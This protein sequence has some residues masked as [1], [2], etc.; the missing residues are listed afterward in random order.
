MPRLYGSQSSLSQ[1]V[2]A[3]R[4]SSTRKKRH[5]KHSFNVLSY[6]FAIQPFM[7]AP[8]LP[9]ETLQRLMFQSRCVTQPVKNAL[10][11]WWAEYY[12]F[13]VKLSDLYEREEFKSMVLNPAWS[14]TNVTTAQGGTSLSQF[15]YYAGGTGMINYV[16]LCRRRVIDEFFRDEAENYTDHEL[17]DGTNTYAVAQIVGNSVFDSVAL[18]DA[19]TAQDVNLLDAAGTEVLTAGEVAAGMQLWEQQRLYGITLLSYEDWLMQFGVNAEVEEPHRPELLRYVR[20]W[21]Y[22][23]NTI[24]PTNGTA[25]SA[26]SWTIQERADKA[27]AFREPG[28]VFGVT[29]IRPKIYQRAQE[30]SFTSVMNDFRTWL[31]PFFANNPELSRKLVAADAGPL[32]TIV[33]DSDGYTVDIKDL[34]LYGEQFSNRSLTAT[35]L[36]FL[37]TMDATLVNK[38]YPAAHADTDELFVTTGGYI[39]QDGIVD[40]EISCA[41][42][43]PMFDTSPR[44]GER[45]GEV[46]ST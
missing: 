9:G 19:M 35:N 38:R 37:D 33:T 26:V 30:G 40:L 46:T 2:A 27:R 20:E 10:I 34:L 32:K 3:V 24:D 16:E 13:Y 6:P 15:D 41:P 25:R 18:Q 21:S 4:A 23:T 12:F 31:P 44:G 14:P 29:C 28:F 39:A 7:I 1:A 45:S 42:T 17:T 5:P 36:N 22:P 8:V 43:N 11:G